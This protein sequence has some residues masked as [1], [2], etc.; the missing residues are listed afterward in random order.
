MHTPELVVRENTL[1]SVIQG[2]AQLI[3]ALNDI[4]VTQ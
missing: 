4:G 1:G 2:D 3:G